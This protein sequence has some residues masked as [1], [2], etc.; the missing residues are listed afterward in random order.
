MYWQWTVFEACV[1]VFEACV[2]HRRTTRTICLAC[3][4]SAIYMGVDRELYSSIV[5]QGSDQGT[6]PRVVLQGSDHRSDQEVLVAACPL[7]TRPS[8]HFAVL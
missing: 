7:Q 1:T 3:D 2:T 4:A 5:L 8:A 6:V